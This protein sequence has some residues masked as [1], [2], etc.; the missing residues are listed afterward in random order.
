[1]GG[2]GIATASVFCFWLIFFIMLLDYIRTYGIKEELRIRA[3]II[4]TIKASVAAL[5]G[6]TIVSLLS[7]YP[8]LPLNPDKHIH[9]VLIIGIMG[10]IYMIIVL[11]LSLL[12]GGEEAKLLK[13][14]FSKVS[15]RVAKRK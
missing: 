15:R 11:A 3:F 2:P 1:M 7:R 9:A 13:D 10:S 8:G 5:A 6:V 4:T 14:L 12:M